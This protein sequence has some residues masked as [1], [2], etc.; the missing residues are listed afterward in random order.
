VRPAH[1]GKQPIQRFYEP[2]LAT[3]ALEVR[4]AASALAPGH[5]PP[6]RECA[7][8]FGSQTRLPY[9]GD[10]LGSA[11]VPTHAQLG[12]PETDGPFFGMPSAAF[13]GTSTHSLTHAQ[14]GVPE[15]DGPFFGMPSA[16]FHGTSTHSL[17]HAQLGVPETDGPFFGM[18]S[19]AFHGTSTH[20]LK[21]K[22]SSNPG[23]PVHLGL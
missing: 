5:P 10:V 16:A 11:G 6:I 2:G 4:G 17:T 18:P 22:R 9:P 13:H 8:G 15:T 1:V 23:R 12:V 19:A 3:Q 7:V 14:L 20:S 21:G